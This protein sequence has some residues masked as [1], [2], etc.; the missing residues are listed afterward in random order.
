MK[1]INS[2]CIYWREERGVGQNGCAS[3]TIGGAKI[4]GA[5]LRVRLTLDANPVI[6]AAFRT[7]PNSKVD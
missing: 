3:A 2:S 5:N 4:G 7:N 6:G 1:R